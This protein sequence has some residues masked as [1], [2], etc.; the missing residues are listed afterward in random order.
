MYS[1]HILRVVILGMVCFAITTFHFL[2]FVQSV[3]EPG[4]V[5]VGVI[6]M[7]QVIVSTGESKQVLAAL[8][9]KFAQRQ[10]IWRFLVNKSTLCV[11]DWRLVKRRSSGKKPTV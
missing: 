6:N 7:Q 8:Q 10:K 1:T 9:G 3:S 5:M 11:S 4:P 2:G